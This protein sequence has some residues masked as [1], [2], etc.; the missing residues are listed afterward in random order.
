M[1][2]VLLPDGQT[3]QIPPGLDEQATARYLR[4][5]GVDPAALGE[6]AGPVDDTYQMQGQGFGL[7][8]MAGAGLFVARRTPVL[9]DHIANIRPPQTAGGVVGGMAVPV[10]ASFL[11]PGSG[12][13]GMG[14]QAALA[15]TFEAMDPDSTPGSVAGQA[16]LAGAGTGAADFLGRA[17]RGAT[18]AVRAML[19]GGVLRNTDEGLRTVAN[20]AGGNVLVDRI[21][22]RA[23]TR[24]AAQSFGANADNLSPQVLDQA[25]TTIGQQF[26]NIL[27][28]VRADLTG[29]QAQVAALPPGAVGGRAARALNSVRNWADVDGQTLRA[30]RQ[31][32][33]ERGRSMMGEAPATADD[34]LLL[35][36]DIDT[37]AEQALGPQFR[38]EFRAAREAWKNLRIIESLP[39]VRKSGGVSAGELS[40]ALAREGRGYGTSFLRDTGNVLPGT[41]RLFDTA[42]ALT[43]D[44]ASRIGN[45][46][47]APALAGT[48]GLGVGAGVLTG[49]TTPQVALAGLAAAGGAQAAGLAAVGGQAP[50]MGRAGAA[51]GRELSRW[52][53]GEDD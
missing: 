32:L 17:A 47:T 31:A 52:L 34:L 28:N 13:V 25:A 26:D 19:R 29:V 48:A 50:T 20:A 40:L 4:A 22:R 12:L 39:T 53:G 21:N 46:G 51:A 23:L 41:Q 24:A 49:A 5:K 10:G 11:V 33:A 9:R 16:A 43:Q 44:A 6:P 30:V 36:D 38:T 27:G 37:V 3:L 15:G 8:A 7:D 18:R 2:G 1:P 14:S 45:P 42:R 35:V